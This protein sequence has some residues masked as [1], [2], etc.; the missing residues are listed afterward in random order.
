MRFVHHFLKTR[1]A[2][3]IGLV[4]SLVGLGCSNGR[5]T[6]SMLPP[7]EF[8][9]SL[10]IPD[11]PP[12]KGTTTIGFFESSERRFAEVAF[13]VRSPASYVVINTIILPEAV[14]LPFLSGERVELTEANAPFGYGPRTA[15][16][17]G[18][19]IDTLT[20]RHVR[21]VE[22][23]STAPGEIAIHIEFGDAVDDQGEVVSEGAVQATLTGRVEFACLPA[24]GQPDPLFS[25]DPFCTG[26]WNDAGGLDQFSDAFAA[27]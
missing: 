5:H 27:R 3:G 16:D 15:D 25:H 22:L 6:G 12:L 26:I 20:Q 1:A 11:A 14:V 19:L 23:E 17:A 21:A 18:F 7:D 8:P 2:L 10:S 9:T 13:F 4:L 24:G